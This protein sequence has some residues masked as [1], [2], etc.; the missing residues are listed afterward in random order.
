MAFGVMFHHFYDQTHPKGQGAIS[1]DDL[2]R[3]IAKIGR[4]AIL[5]AQDWAE[6]ARANMLEPSDI[7]LTFDD[8]LLCQYDVARP[9]LE[10]YGL[11]AFWFVYS[12]VFEG[13]QEPLELY[14]YFRTTRY[15][16]VDAFYGDFFKRTVAE[17]SEAFAEAAASFNADT[18]LA[19]FAFY[20]R[21]DRFFR[22]LRD[23]VLGPDRYHAIMRGLMEDAGFDLAEA[24]QA[25][26]MTDAHLSQLHSDGH[27]I[28]LHSYSHP[29][30]LA[31]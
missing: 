3:L 30:R 20:T 28:G 11:T 21:E 19:E 18:Y 6:R 12:S 29:T 24:A 4:D 27:V 26:W 15:E 10:A 31:E 22:Y 17:A 2:E 14:R 23:D 16:T 25:L 9:V 8:A 13:N 5:P 1:A 7:C